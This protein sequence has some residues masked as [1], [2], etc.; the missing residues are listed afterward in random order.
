MH[1]F[2]ALAASHLTRLITC[3][4]CTATSMPQLWTKLMPTPL[5]AISP[6][7]MGPSV[8]SLSYIKTHSSL[9]ACSHLKEQAA[10]ESRLNPLDAV[11]SNSVFYSVSIVSP[12]VLDSHLLAM[13][14]HQGQQ[15]LQECILAAG[16]QLL[17]TLWFCH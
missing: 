9:S 15:Q 5:S 8:Y 3:R 11:N 16:Q 1:A 7:S 13:A 4:L 10:S 14:R 17:P 2:I 6:P 12:V